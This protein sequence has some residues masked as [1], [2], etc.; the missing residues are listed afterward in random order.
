MK[1]I[2]NSRKIQ[3]RSPFGA[4]TTGSDIVL[5]IDISGFAPESVTLMLWND[6]S[7]GPEYITMHES[8]SDREGRTYTAS[9]TA[10]EKGGLLWY[11]LR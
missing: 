9:L 10:P 5:S 1:I 11:A 2:H 7:V 6:A 3:Y 4:V 8:D